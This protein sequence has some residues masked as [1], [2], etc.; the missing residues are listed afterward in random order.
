[1][2]AIDF[3]LLLRS[4]LDSR[5]IRRTHSR[6]EVTEWGD[7]YRISLCWGIPFNANR[8]RLWTQ[9]AIT[10]LSS[11]RLTHAEM[12]GEEASE[13]FKAMLHI[14]VSWRLWDI[15]LEA[16]AFYVILNRFLNLLRSQFN[17]H[18]FSDLSVEHHTACLC[19]SFKQ[20][21][22]K[23]LLQIHGNYST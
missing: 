18:L 2:M 6:K 12:V 1:M 11:L 5:Y 19:S 8:R 4:S 7:H 13:M 15:V 22:A 23:M 9:T 20:F 10:I 14:V 3:C 21:T 16:F 17:L